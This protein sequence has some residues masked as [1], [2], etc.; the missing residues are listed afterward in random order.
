M[1][2]SEK[3]KSKFR[4]RKV[5]KEFRKEM[6]KLKKNDPITGSKLTKLFHLHHCDFNENHYT[7]L[8]PENFECLN[9][10]SHDVVHYFF[11]VPGKIK[12][13][14]LLVLRLITILK[15]MERLNKEQAN[16]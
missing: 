15:K 5:W 12:P 14:R 11:G 2:L 6:K 13:W 7:N 10:M 1:S 4:T 9:N 8:V 3:E 16:G